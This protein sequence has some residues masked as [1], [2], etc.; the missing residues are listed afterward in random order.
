MNIKKQI[1]R[2]AISTYSNFEKL[3]MFAGAAEVVYL[4]PS[5]KRLEEIK[6]YSWSLMKSDYA[7]HEV[8]RKA[9]MLRSECESQQMLKDVLARFSRL[10]REGIL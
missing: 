5:H 1:K 4:N 6:A 9:R 10:R 8:K 7:S 2:T 3:R